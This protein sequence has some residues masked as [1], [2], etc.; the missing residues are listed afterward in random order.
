MFARAAIII[1]LIPMFLLVPVSGCHAGEWD[2]ILIGFVFG[3]ALGVV[4]GGAVI[5]FYRNP[6]ADKN[7]ETI[8]IT[9]T[10]IGAAAGITYGVLLPDDA[11]EKDPIISMAPGSRNTWQVN[12]YSPTFSLTA[13][14]AGDN[15]IEP[16]IHAQLLR[17][18]F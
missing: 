5:I 12:V 7:L 2:E 15:S 16:G 11:R 17:L 3:T 13:M 6:D 1:V 10:T 18:D 8:L 9:S 14:P 4:A